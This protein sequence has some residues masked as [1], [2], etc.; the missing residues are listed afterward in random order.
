MITNDYFICT[1]VFRDIIVGGN[2][3]SYICAWGYLRTTLSVWDVNT[4][5]WSSGLGAVR[6]ADDLAL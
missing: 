3:F 4:E 1:D 6:R 2:I 5:I